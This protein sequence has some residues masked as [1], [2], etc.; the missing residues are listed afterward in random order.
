MVLT[1][2]VVNYFKV[3]DALSCSHVPNTQKPFRTISTTT[4]AFHFASK[5]SLQLSV[6]EASVTFNIPDLRS[7]LWEYLS[8]LPNVS[9]HLVSR[10]RTQEQNCTLPF[11]HIQIWHKVCVQQMYYYESQTP[12]APQTLRALPPSTTKRHGVYDAVIVNAE[13]ESNWPRCGLE[14]K[15][16]HLSACSHLKCAQAIQLSSCE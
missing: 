10:V 14:G 12:D 8:R 3:A 6:D 16:Q 4:T 2:S 7:A 11:E 15:S 13:P 1:R 5:P 9:S